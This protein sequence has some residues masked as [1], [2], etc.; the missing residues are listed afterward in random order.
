M[1]VL[2][3]GGNGILGPYVVR[4]LE[5]HHTLRITD[6][7]P[8]EDTKHEFLT[9]DMSSIDQVRFLRQFRRC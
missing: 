7:K 4:A 6:I 8:L 2:I 5:P 9:V 1:N 3:L